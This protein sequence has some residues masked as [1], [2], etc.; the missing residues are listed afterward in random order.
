MSLASIIN[1]FHSSVVSDPWEAPETDVISVHQSAFARCC[2]AVAAIRARPRTTS[3]LLYGEAGSGKTHLLARLRAHIAR[4]AEADGPGGLQ[5]AI[6]VSAPLRTSARLI[7][8]HMRD[9]L[10]S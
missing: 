6:F 4:E 9:C 10:V 8:R 3:A 1:P 7:W 2:D 5:D